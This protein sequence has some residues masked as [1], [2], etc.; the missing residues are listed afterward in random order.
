MCERRIAKF[1]HWS[2]FYYI[3]VILTLAL[4]FDNCGGRRVEKEEC[5]SA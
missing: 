1:G 3:C 4:R 5:F 2:I